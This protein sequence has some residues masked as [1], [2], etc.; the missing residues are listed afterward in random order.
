MRIS[1]TVNPLANKSFPALQASFLLL[2]FLPLN[3]LAQSSSTLSGLVLDPSG[4]RI[5]H[6]AI[7][8][9]NTANSQSAWT[10]QTDRTGNFT[11][12]IPP[13]TYDL[14]ITAP[15]FSPD[16]VQALV[17]ADTPHPPLT[18]HLAIAT[19]AEVV[20]VPTQN[21]SSTSAADNKSAMIF[22][23]ERLNMLSDDNATM[24]QQLLALAGGDPSRTPD[25]Y[26]DGFSGGRFPPKS[27]IREVRINQNP[28]SAQYPSYGSNRMEIFTKPGGDTYHGNLFAIGNDAPLNANT[29]YTEVAPP[30]Y[31]YYLDGFVSGPLIDKRTSFFAGSTYHKMQ[32]NSVVNAVDPATFGPLSESLSTP[33]NTQ[34]YTARIDR[35][36][37]TN[38][39][40]T[41]RYEYRRETLTNGGIGS[42]V[43][44][45]EAVDSVNLSQTLQLGDTQIL[46]PKIISESRF[47]YIRTRVEQQAE[48]SAPTVIVQGSFNGGG[49][50]IGNQHDNQDLYEFQEYLSFE[51][52][53]HFFRAGARY[54][55]TRE[56]NHSTANYNGVYTFPDLLSYKLTLAGDTPAQI[57]AADPGVT[58]QF[59]LTAGQSD[60]V[61]TSGLLGAYVED[62][63]K[64]SKS[65]TLNAGLRLESQSAIPDHADCAPR[66]AVAWAVGQGDKKPALFVLRAG[67]GIF[68]DRFTPSDIFTTVRQN[69]LSQQTVTVNNP[70]FFLPAQ[71]PTVASLET[72]ANASSPIPYRIDPH[73]RTRYDQDATVTVEH[74]LGNKG[75]LTATYWWARGPHQ[76]LSQNINAPLPG[77]YNPAD[78]ASGIRPLGDTQNIYEFTSNGIAKGNLFLVFANLQASKRLSLFTAYFLQN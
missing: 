27:Q 69:G 67:F 28:F 7:H 16:T 24:Q 76:Y 75:N 66:V 12:T 8:I 47:Q 37:S 73:L 34:T 5:G 41:S 53:K 1:R 26:I 6:A 18:I 40:F 9:V 52:G 58:T 63:W 44:P 57:Q 62:E 55:L 31:S 3:A 20:N 14:T 38:N 36:M 29:P 17:V 77:T 78:P 59:S 46:T 60:F 33:D 64:L 2:A 61:L 49:S 70:G 51:Q 32:N 71:P 39:T 48:N 21:E 4:A 10:L 19:E 30:Y 50:S 13:G 43:L 68:Y 42:L 54:D 72:G 15:G 25:V 65:I 45:S 56:A 22:D 11:A 74:S 23:K 35:Q